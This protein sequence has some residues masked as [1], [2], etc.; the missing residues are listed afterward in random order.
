MY[1]CWLKLSGS[2]ALIAKNC[3]KWPIHV[4]F[5]WGNI[6]DINSLIKD[7]CINTAYTRS[8][9]LYN[10]ELLTVKLIVYG[11]LKV[12]FIFYC[13][14]VAVS[15]STWIAISAPTTTLW[16]CDKVKVILTG[17]VVCCVGLWQTIIDISVTHLCCIEVWMERKFTIF[18]M[19]CSLHVTEKTLFHPNFGWHVTQK[20]YWF[21]SESIAFSW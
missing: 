14:C 15:C 10:V 11:G 21:M 17:G 12:L 1:L 9:T 2:S 6:I 3:L 7:F 18:P 5:Y 8:I 4:H 16:Y 13:I 20:Q 19:V